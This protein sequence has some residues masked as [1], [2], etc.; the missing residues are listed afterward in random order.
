MDYKA[1]IANKI[2]SVLNIGQEDVMRL[3]EI[4]PRP[5]MGDYAFPCFSLAKTLRKAPN[6]IAGELKEQLDIKE[7]ER[8]EV[9]GPY[10]NFFLD[11]TEFLSGAVSEILE[12]GEAYGRTETGEGKTVIVEYSSPNIAKPFHVGH[13]FTTVIGNSLSRIFKSQGYKTERINHLG[14]WGTQFGKLISGYERWVDLEKLKEAP[15]EELNRIYVKFHEEAEKEPSLNDEA[16]AHFKNLEDGKEYEVKLWKEFRELSLMVFE[17]VYKEL[18]VEFDSYAGESFYG[19][20]MDEVVDILEDKGILTESNGAQVVM[21]DEYNMPPTIIKKADGATI[22][23]TRDLAAAIYRKRTYDFFKNIYVVGTPQSLHFRQ[24]FKTL[25]LAGFEWAK[26]CVHVGFG[27]VK[28]PGKMMSSRKGDV[29]L[30]DDLLKEAVVTAEKIIHDKNPNLKDKEDVAHKVGIGA[31]I[32]TY[33]KNGREKDIIFDW[34]EILSFDGET[35]PYVQYT[36]ARAKSILRKNDTY[37]DA[38]LSVLTGTEEFELSKTLASFASAVNQAME[39]YEPS[40][41]TRYVL[42]VAKD[43]NKFYNNCP[44]NSAETSVKKARLQLVDATT[45]VIKNALALLGIETVEEM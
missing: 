12:K 38:D 41:I 8:I 7:V 9:L 11:K 10:L 26:D 3:L 20:K 31:V 39:K 19:D 16:R 21:L 44:I 17:R 4:P 29:V 13:L 15:I 23:A 33:L 35:G 43:F 30:L 36:Y 1:V 34:D 45:V 6:A 14:D 25:E 28:F 32:F 40:V 24:V 27:L 5:E 37:N 42:Q 18:G 2:S 22:Y